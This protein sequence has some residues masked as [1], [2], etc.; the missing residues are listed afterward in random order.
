[1]KPTALLIPLMFATPAEAARDA[2]GIVI[3][4][5]AWVSPP[6][7][8]CDKNDDE[9]RVMCLSPDRV[10]RACGALVGDGS[11]QPYGCAAIM[12]PAAC[13]VI[14]N[15][16]LPGDELARVI[17]HEKAHCRGWPPSHPLD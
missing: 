6:A 7:W 4:P 16:T 11:R 3:P 15:E 9:A 14:V 1:M 13:I 17:E 2:F 8:T 5:S 10:E 12:A